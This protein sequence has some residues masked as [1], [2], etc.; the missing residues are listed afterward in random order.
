MRFK[1]PKFC[2][3]GGHPTGKPH[4]RAVY[5]GHIFTIMYHMPGMVKGDPGNC[6]IMWH[7]RP[8]HPRD[9]NGSLIWENTFAGPLG[10]TGTYKTIEQAQRA[11]LTICATLAD[12]KG[13]VV[14]FP[15]L[16]LE[17][18]AQEGPTIRGNHELRGLCI[19]LVRHVNSGPSQNADQ[20]EA[21]ALASAEIA[22]A[23]LATPAKS[24]TDFGYK[25]SAAVAVTVTH[26]D[27]DGAASIL[28]AG[29]LDDFNAL[30]KGGV[31]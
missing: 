28:L 22:N 15:T 8:D 3:Y 25:L 6:W 20:R 1:A 18:G 24:I 23:V 11:V 13:N 31:S 17:S 2:T 12:T 19:R 16:Q 7:H 10:C 27:P 30:Q 29:V 26:L 21:D 9:V 4:Y 14:P 5:H